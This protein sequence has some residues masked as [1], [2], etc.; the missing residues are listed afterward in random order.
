MKIVRNVV[1]FALCCVYQSVLP[2]Y[3]EPWTWFFQK[4][5]S[6]DE[7]V[8]N[9]NKKDIT[10]FKNTNREFSQLVFS[11]NAFRPESGYLSF[12]IQARDA[13][14]KLWGS[15]HKMMEW[16]AIVQRSFMS[17]GK[18]Y[19]RYVHVRLET[20]KNHLSDAF[21]LKICTHGDA[22]LSA[23]K[24][25]SVST[26]NFNK[27]KSEVIDKRLLSLPSVVVKAVPKKS[28][29]MLDHPDNDS[30]CSPTSCS[31]LTSF[32]LDQHVDPIDFAKKGFDRGLGAYGSWP[33]NMAHA[34][35]RCNG[36]VWFSTA[37]VNSFAALHG[38]LR[39]GV[40]VVVSV[41][42]QLKGAPKQYDKG[43]LLVV[44][45]WDAKK[46]HVICH[47]PAVAHDSKVQM[48]YELKSFLQAWERSRRLVYLAEPVKT[49]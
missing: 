43:H 45:G 16:G 7:N 6:A 18:G 38:R 17:R 32:L 15:W 4:I 8:Q 49:F 13:K 27:F 42:G 47:D 2:N 21:R 26:S 14:S 44:V 40:P 48:R 30:L 34:F 37:R 46:R 28:Q 33:F 10:F 36:T 3:H 39:L 19:T 11:W 29:F 9:S 25:F 31:M 41:R 35:E 1:M 24:S 22:N 12:W 23:L 5:F 20:N